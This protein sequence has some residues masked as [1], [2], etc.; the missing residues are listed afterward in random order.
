M[1]W[2]DRKISV[3]GTVGVQIEAFYQYQVIYH[4]ELLVLA[5]IS[6]QSDGFTDEKFTDT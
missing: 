4:P 1:G 3:L 2:R 5:M 6:F